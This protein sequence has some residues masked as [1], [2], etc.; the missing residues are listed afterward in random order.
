MFTLLKAIMTIPVNETKMAMMSDFTIG[1][2]KKKLLI[3]ATANGEHATMTV[4]TDKGRFLNEKMIKINPMFP[5]TQ[6]A[7]SG[8][9]MSLVMPS[10]GCTRSLIRT[11]PAVMMLQMLRHHENSSTVTPERFVTD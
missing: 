6:R 1:S 10:N 2:F 4:P 11:L 3:T 8:S 7:A 9:H 5:N